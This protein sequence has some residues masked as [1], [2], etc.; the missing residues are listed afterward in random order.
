METTGPSNG[1]E[2][3][4]ANPPQTR[5]GIASRG[6]SQ[7]ARRQG[8]TGWLPWLIPLLA[9]TAAAVI[10]F[11]AFAGRGPVIT[12]DFDRGD[13]LAAGDPVTFRGVRVGD[14]RRVT[15][16]PDL[17]R[18]R[19][20][21]RLRSDAA[22]LAV[23]GSQ[24][25]VVRPEISATRVSGLDALLGPRYLECI[26]GSGKRQTSF[27]GLS[28]PPG[29]SVPKDGALNVVVEAVDRG[30]L[31]VDAP[32]TYR[33]VRVGAVKSLALST[34]AQLVE[35]TVAIDPAYRHLVRA[36]SKFWN[37]GGFGMDVGFKGI[38]LKTP[39]IETAITG[40]IAFAT[41]TKAADPAAEGARFELA[42]KPEA[43]WLEWSP[44]LEK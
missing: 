1:A 14:I 8:G 26:P 24:F 6:P 3:A 4:A 11:Q 20:E 38:S 35:V 13:G 22:G 29:R 9:I 18:V 40:G 43:E 2:A 7:P 21:A 32:V 31:S 10:G 15:L 25:W 33:G 42:E 17:A 23:E 41:P 34:N 12:I 36:N 19:V 28:T 5:T 27:E 30:S 16:S 37:A 44:V 39:T